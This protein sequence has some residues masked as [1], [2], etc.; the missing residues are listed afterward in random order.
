VIVAVGG[1]LLLL[2]GWAALHWERTYRTKAERVKR[3]RR[4]ALD[5]W[6]RKRRIGYVGAALVVVS[7]APIAFA[8]RAAQESTQSPAAVTPAAVSSPK[9]GDEFPVEFLAADS[10]GAIKVKVTN[11]TDRPAFV[12]CIV[13]AFD[14]SGSSV[15]EGTYDAFEANGDEYQSKGYATVFDLDAG[16]K[17][18][19]GVNLQVGGPVA[20]VEGSC[21]EVPEPPNGAG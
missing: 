21:G 15:I 1:G 18:R 10:D 3:A 14:A 20:S 5:A 7:L 6:I 11:E 13:D 2:V 12:Q 17:V 19:L 9:P 16:A 4:P 8:Q